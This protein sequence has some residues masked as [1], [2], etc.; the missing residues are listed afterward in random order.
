MVR[1]SGNV[2]PHHKEPP[3]ELLNYVEAHLM[4][5]GGTALT[6]QIMFE[7]APDGVGEQMVM[8]ALHQLCRV[9]RAIRRWS[10][11]DGH[12]EFWRAQA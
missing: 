12:W 4:P 2:A 7:H 9:G 8:N 10:F 11:R 3:P 6:T 5:P 1:R